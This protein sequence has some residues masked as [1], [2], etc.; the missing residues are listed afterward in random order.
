M[1][2]PNIVVIITDQQA[3]DA[4]SCAGNE[5]LRTPAMDRV[6]GG[7]VLFRNAYCAH[8]L[9]T[10]ARMCMMTGRHSHETGVVFNCMTHPV[11]VPMLGRAIAGAGYDTG[12]VGKWHLTVPTDDPSQH[13][14]ESVRYANARATPI[15]PAD[16]DYPMAATEFLAQDRTDPFLLFVSFI[17][18]H[19]ICQ[20]ARG[21]PLPDGPV[22]DPPPPDL[23]PPLP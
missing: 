20:Y 16:G 8:P 14:F 18:P 3:A 15:R 13:G 5:H 19:N 2:R 12:Y 10:P 9:C 6:A 11:S 17:N 22:A 7:G 1:S 4:M 21:E 23:C